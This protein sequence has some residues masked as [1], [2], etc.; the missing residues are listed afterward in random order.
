MCE[1]VDYAS[2]IYS[3]YWPAPFL[4]AITYGCIEHAS[5]ITESGTKYYNYSIN[6][7]G[8][9]NTVDALEAI[10]ELVYKQRVTS[11]K[12]IK[13]ALESDFVGY[14]WLRKKML[15]C[16]KYGNDMDFVDDKM[17]DLMDSFT[18]YIHNKKTINRK[19]KFQCGCYSVMHHALLGKKTAASCDGRY[20]GTSL[21]NSLSPV[22]GMDKYGP[23]AVM[24]SINKVSMDYMGNGSV[25]DMKFTPLFLAEK[26]NLDA[27]KCLIQTYFDEGGLEVQFNVVDKETL[28]KAQKEP[29]KY[30]NLV[31]RVSGFSAYFKNLDKEV[32]DE[33]IKRTESSI[34]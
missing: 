2:T 33:I 9:A 27:L 14:E 20:A 30:S 28:I 3:Q 11:L 7:V 31:V 18:R 13:E 12:E 4:S 23:I 26:R 34:S 17:K 6:C 10:D 25:L 8:M 29:E 21:A 15:E 16:Q 5:D 22:Q 24:E 1:F 32:Q 19:R